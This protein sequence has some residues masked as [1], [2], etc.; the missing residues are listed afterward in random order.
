MLHVNTQQYKMK[1]LLTFLYIVIEKI[2]TTT[3]FFGE[4]ISS[5][6]AGEVVLMW[7]FS[8]KY[9]PAFLYTTPYHS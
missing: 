8:Y 2:V 5:V 9:L 3:H 1:E 6:S 4:L 7:S